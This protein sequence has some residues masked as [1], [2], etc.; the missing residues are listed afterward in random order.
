MDVVELLEGVQ[1]LL[2]NFGI[3]SQ[4]NKANLTPELV[5]SKANMNVFADEIGFLMDY[6][7]AALEDYIARGSAELRRA[8]HCNGGI[9]HA[10]W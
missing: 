2:L 3:A 10:R 1:Q 5:I 7:Q 8:L 9:D 6:K 4:I